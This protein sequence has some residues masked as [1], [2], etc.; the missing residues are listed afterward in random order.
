MRWIGP[1][2]ASVDGA[3]DALQLEIW[4][5]VLNYWTVVGFKSVICIVLALIASGELVF[6]AFPP[7]MAGLA[8]VVMSAQLARSIYRASKITF[9][10]PLIVL[11]PEGIQHQGFS[12][13]LHWRVISKISKVNRARTSE[14]TLR[15][16]VR[17]DADP[18]LLSDLFAWA[19]G[20]LPR[21]IFVPL[22]RIKGCS[23]KDATSIIDRYIKEPVL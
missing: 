23:A 22:D 1:A 21:T 19:W 20:I 9:S 16:V 6:Q 4:E 10:R 2:G 5:N 18:K 7:F 13:S 14:R 3:G 17:D 15:L 11:S 8:L 12:A